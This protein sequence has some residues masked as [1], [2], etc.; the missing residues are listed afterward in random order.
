MQFAMP[1]P[2][3]LEK[4]IAHFPT[5]L[6]G[7]ILVVPYARHM[8]LTVLVIVWSLLLLVPSL[9]LWKYAFCLSLAIVSTL[10]FGLGMALASQ[11]S[12]RA[13]DAISV[14]VDHDFKQQH[15]SIFTTAV[16]SDVC[17]AG[18]AIVAIAAALMFSGNLTSALVGCR[19][20]GSPDALAQFIFN[21]T[22]AST[23]TDWTELERRPYFATEFLWYQLCLDDYAMTIA[24]VVLGYASVLLC[25]ATLWHE[26]SLRPE[27]AR[28]YGPLLQAATGRGARTPDSPPNSDQLL[29]RLVSNARLSSCQNRHL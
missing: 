3:P 6:L 7:N 10:M 28:M 29:A 8:I 25:G 16:G 19:S 12:T 9:F 15:H 2:S 27:T 20:R 21:T 22:N 17:V 4:V 1:P 14:T 18:L 5:F 13:F 26:L 11:A 24:W 23:V